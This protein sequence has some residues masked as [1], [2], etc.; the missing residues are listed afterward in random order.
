M[1]TQALNVVVGKSIDNPLQ[2]VLCS[3]A[4]QLAAGFEAL[5]TESE[6]TGRDIHDDAFLFDNFTPMTPVEQW[7]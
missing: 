2:A 5:D 7:A 6:F 4:C 3:C 1:L